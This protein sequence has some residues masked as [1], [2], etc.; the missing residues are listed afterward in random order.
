[1]AKFILG[2]DL[3]LLF[4][5]YLYKKYFLFLYMPASLLYKNNLMFPKSY[6]TLYFI[7]LIWCLIY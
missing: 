7:Y 6:K 2:G 5:I 3:L 1:M 4:I